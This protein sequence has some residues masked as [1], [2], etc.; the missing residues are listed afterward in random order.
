MARH[1]LDCYAEEDKL[2]V[3]ERLRRMMHRR[4]IERDSYTCGAPECLQRGSLE[5]DHMRE[6]S[7]GGS[8][9]VE[10]QKPLC[11]LEHQ[12]SKHRARTLKLYGT[13]PD[14]VTIRMGRRIYRNDTILFP[15]FDERV[16]DEDPWR[17]EVER[18]E[19]SPWV[20]QDSPRP[21]PA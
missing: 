8:L 12:V 16:L 3:P 7:L 10:N 14:D 13:A 9:G 21:E 15:A 18:A 19:D 17:L 4:V 20:T 6:R 2:A 1:F 5:S 11:S